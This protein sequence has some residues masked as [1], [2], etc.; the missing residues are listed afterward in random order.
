MREALFWA[1]PGYSSSSVSWANWGRGG[2]ARAGEALF[3]DQTKDTQV[4]LT[5]DNGEPIKCGCV[6]V[7]VCVRGRGCREREF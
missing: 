3:W 6:Y 7:C 5:D 1:Q 4:S 2:G